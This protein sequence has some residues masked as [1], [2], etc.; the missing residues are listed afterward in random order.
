[1][2]APGHC[3]LELQRHFFLGAHGSAAGA[4]NAWV[5]AKIRG[6]LLGVPLGREE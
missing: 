4:L 6:I 5:V 3:L 2:A 1:V